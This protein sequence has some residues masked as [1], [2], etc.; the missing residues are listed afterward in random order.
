MVR[1][2]GVDAHGAPTFLV[3]VVEDDRLTLERG[4]LRRCTLVLR[5]VISG[6]KVRAGRAACMTK[7]AVA[8]DEL[9]ENYALVE[10]FS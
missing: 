9:K 4:L 7:R 5:H 8:F 1:P 3:D 10:G 2:D 6:N